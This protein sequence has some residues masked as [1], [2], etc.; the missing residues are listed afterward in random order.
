LAVLPVALVAVVLVSIPVH[1]GVL[2]IHSGNAE[3]ASSNPLT[4]IPPASLERFGQAFFAPMALIYAA[5]KTAP[6]HRP[7]VAGVL[8][9]LY[10]VSL[11]AVMMY[12]ASSGFYE[13]KHWVEFVVVV[14]LGIVG[15]G[16]AAYYA[17]R[18]EWS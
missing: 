11:G 18:G 10:A 6:A 2:M 9:I 4:A 13:G 14:G 5:V 8:V 12:A 3:D 16:T 7:Y 15:L 1:L 17:Y